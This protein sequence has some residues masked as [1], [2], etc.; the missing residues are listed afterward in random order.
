[1]NLHTALLQGSKLLED[2][3]IGVARLTAEVLLCHALHCER[4]YLYGHPERE[5]QEVEWIHYGRY[6]HE[7]LKG[8][9]T[10]YITGR[11]EFYSR[12][13]R[14][15]PAVFIPRPETE[16]VI[17]TALAVNRGARRILDVGTGSGAIGVTMRLETGAQVFATDLSRQ[18]LEVASG[19]AQ[20]LGAPITFICCDLVSAVAS[21]SM[22]LIVSNPPYVP[23]TDE[24]A[25]QREVRDWEPELALFGGKTGLEVYERLA[26]EAARVLVPQGWLVMELGFQSRDRVAEMLRDWS[27]VR[28]QPDL[29]G[30]PR[31]IKARLA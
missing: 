27:E 13:F 9:P 4:P 14:V 31:V 26:A 20:R 12:E 2:G 28:V 25:L 29:A 5:L 16:C 6:L 18:A 21:R 19:N 7:R 3:G 24:P 8:K 15:T 17:E 30:I 10:Q 11:Q 1:V 23:R 22:D